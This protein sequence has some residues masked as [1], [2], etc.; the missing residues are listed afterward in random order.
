MTGEESRGS[1][2]DFRK[3]SIQTYPSKGLGTVYREVGESRVK[4]L[5]LSPWVFPCGSVLY[6]ICP[7]PVSV[8]GLD[9]L[10]YFGRDGMRTETSQRLSKE[11]PL[12]VLGFT[13][14]YRLVPFSTSGRKPLCVCVCVSRTERL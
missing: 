4:C 14:F 10:Q 11:I 9:Y 1:V 6:R 8:E 13:V 12:V 2:L 5:L 7:T 3:D